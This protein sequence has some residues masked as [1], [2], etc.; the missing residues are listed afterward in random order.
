MAAQRFHANGPALF[1]VLKLTPIPDP[2]SFDRRSRPAS[3]S[4]GRKHR[5]SGGGR[6][7]YHKQRVRDGA[8]PSNRGAKSAQLLLPEPY[9]RCSR[10]RSESYSASGLGFARVPR[11]C[12]RLVS[13]YFPIGPPLGLDLDPVSRRSA[14]SSN[15]SSGRPDRRKDDCQHYH[16]PQPRV[17]SERLPNGQ[18]LAIDRDANQPSVRPTKVGYGRMFELR[19]TIRAYD[20]EIRRVVADAWVEVVHLKIRFSVTLF[21]GER[22]KL[23]PATMQLAKKDANPGRNDAAPFGH[24]RK[25][26]WTRLRS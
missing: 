26:S 13:P 19:V 7:A 21:E 2:R 17:Y 16:C 5:S 18:T 24:G 11:L 15:C 14:S 23:A 9:S 3:D 12:L 22:T 25:D 4:L 20:K 1:L 6:R 10:R 8:R